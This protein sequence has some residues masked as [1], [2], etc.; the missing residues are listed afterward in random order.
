[1]LGQP[2]RQILRI[3]PELIAKGIL[4]LR[5]QG[6]L[7]PRGVPVGKRDLI[8]AFE[9]RSVRAVSTTHQ[10]RFATQDRSGAEDQ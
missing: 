7:A 2:V 4:V 9:Y 8:V 6:I 1:M 10:D 5:H 3:D